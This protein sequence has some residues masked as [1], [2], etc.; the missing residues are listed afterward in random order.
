MRRAP[1]SHHRSHRLHSRTIRL[2]TMHLMYS[3]VCL[4]MW[5]PLARSTSPSR[6]VAVMQ[7]CRQAHESRLRRRGTTRQH[8]RW[9]RGIAELT[10]NIAVGGAEGGGGGT[11]EASPCA[12]S[13][14]QTP[15]LH[16]PRP[17]NTPFKAQSQLAVHSTWY[18]ACSFRPSTK[19]G[20]S[21]SMN[22]AKASPV[23]ARHPPTQVHSG[24]RCE[25]Q[26]ATWYATMTTR[27]GA[28]YR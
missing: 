5:T 15:A 22:T 27:G 20:C 13:F 4:A 16:G 6:F 17:P 8:Q 23:T 7:I 2:S 11:K 9:A 18:S 12:A 21:L 1:H 25:E 24:A 26:T 19:K 28:P 3:S 14:E 10:M